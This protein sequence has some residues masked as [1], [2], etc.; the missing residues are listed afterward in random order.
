M[1]DCGEKQAEA[2]TFFDPEATFIRMDRVSIS[3]G[4]SESCKNVNT[5][6]R[7]CERDFGRYAEVQTAGSGPRVTHGQKRGTCNRS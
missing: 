2:R 4:N 1:A 5:Q 7:K 6:R 3:A